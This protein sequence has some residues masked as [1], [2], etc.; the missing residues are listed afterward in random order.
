MRPHRH[1]DLAA[2]EP[3]DDLAPALRGQ[4]PH[5]ELGANARA[6]EVR[7][8]RAR[9]LLGQDLGRGHHRGLLLV[10]HRHE[11]RVQRH[12][13]LPRADVALEQPRHRL[14]RAQV[15]ND[16]P[17]RPVLGR[18]QV[19]GKP[20]PDPPV[21]LAVELHRGA[22]PV[23]LHPVP[24][25]RERALQQEQLVVLESLRGR[26][27]VLHRVREVDP[28]DGFGEADE[29]SLL[30]Q[31]VREE[32]LDPIGRGLHR[33]EGHAAHGGRLDPAGQ[34]V[35]RH[36]PAGVE[37]GVVPFLGEDLHLGIGDAMA[38]LERDPARDDDLVPLVIVVA[39]VGLVPVQNIER[40]RLVED[41]DGHERESAPEPLERDGPDA[42]SDRDQVAV[43]DRADRREAAPILVT[44]GIVVE[45]ILD[46]PD[47]E[48]L[49]R[50][51]SRRTH[52]LDVL[53]EAIEIQTHSGLMCGKRTGPGC[54]H[55]LRRRRLHGRVSVP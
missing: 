31:P 22:A 28:P 41:L 3:R 53:D 27:D 10:R 29:T 39:P 49:E 13:R 33:G 8:E 26:L 38:S 40:A 32:L 19:K 18:R 47:A 52:A 30:D 55:T 43:L 23:A 34:P 54:Y 42:P 36:D 14:R 45:E 2:R 1:V 24:A 21:H 17:D 7:R 5:Q 46:R 48:V 35:D 9:V 44:L 12:R 50:P 15:R 37:R 6:L 51:G 16:L 20:A 11:D 4:A 25:H